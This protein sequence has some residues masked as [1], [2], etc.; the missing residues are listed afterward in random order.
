MSTRLTTAAVKKFQKR[1]KRREI[2]DS[3][4]RGLYL[5][6]ETTGHKSFALRFRRPGGRLAKL[7]LG[8][9]DFSGKEPKG[10]PVR[11]TP[12]TLAG[13][14]ALAAEIHRQRKVDR[15]RDVVSDFLAEKHRQHA[16]RAANLKNTFAA[17]A[18][19]FIEQ[20][21]RPKVRHWREM[22]RLLGFDPKN[23]LAIISNGLAARW[24][25]KPLAQ[26]DGHDV[27]NLIEE[28]RQYGAPGLERRSDGPTESRARAMLACLSKLFNWLKQPPRRVVEKNPCDGLDRPE[29]NER[30]RVL[31][32]AEVKSFWHA[33]DRVGEPFGQVLKILLLTGCRLREVAGMKRSE[34][35]DDGVIWTIPGSRTKNGRTHVLTLPPAVRSIIKTVKPIAG[36]FVFTTTGTAPVNSWSRIKLRLD[37]TMKPAQPWRLHDLRRTCASGMQRLKVRSEVI[38]RA[39]NHLSGTFRGVA[40]IYQRDPLTEDVREALQRWAAHVEGLVA[41]RP[42]NVLEMKRAQH[43]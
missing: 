2:L 32:D 6:V 7:H 36:D 40:G 37:D 1:K 10:I 15:D 42:P 41:G 14:R 29:M 43:D 35:S 23:D 4:C 27:H 31:T 19:D 26:I 21:A 9:V 30:E 22:A 11:G 12:L 38:E 3:L 16:A 5:V 20:H 17:A 13:A 25:D 18:K 39:L 28:T 24:H 33:C 34:L 8:P